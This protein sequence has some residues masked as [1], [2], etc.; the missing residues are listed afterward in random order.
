MHKTPALSLP[1]SH[2]PRQPDALISLPT[3]PGHCVVA[4]Q[5][6][7]ESQLTEA[8]A[9]SRPQKL[10]LPSVCLTRLMQAG[11]SPVSA[12]TTLISRFKVMK[13]E[14]DACPAT[15]QVLPG[16]SGRHHVD[17]LAMWWCGRVKSY[18]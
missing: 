4:A 6:R 13:I 14:G 15:G 7:A 2:R 12:G 10:D 9:S 16:S 1:P 17:C 11:V 8:E 3:P 18:V 5:C